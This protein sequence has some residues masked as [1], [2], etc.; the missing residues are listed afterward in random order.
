MSRGSLLDRSMRRRRTTGAVAAMVGLP[1]ELAHYT[2][3]VQRW[4]AGN[5]IQLLRAG[6]ETYPA[7]YAAIAS[8]NVSICVETYILDDDGV[9][10]RFAD[11][12][13]E[14]ARAGIT[15]RVLYD[16]VGGW[17]IDGGYLDRLR[18]DGVRVAEFHPIAPWRRRWGLSRRDHRKILVVDDRV[19]FT[20]GLNLSDDYAPAEEGGGDWHDIHCELHGPIVADL[21]RLFRKTWIYSGG[22]NYPVAAEG[23]LVPAVDGAMTF[24]RVLDNSFR[25]R[26]RVIRR[27][28]LVAINAARH[29]VLLANAYFLPDRGLRAALRRAVARGVVVRVIVPGRSDVLIVELAALYLYRRLVKAG[30]EILRWR[31][32]MMHAKT[33]VIDGVWATIGSYNLDSISLQRNLEVTVETLDR[34]HGAIMRAQHATDATH[35][36]PFTEEAWHALPWWRRAISWLAYQ[37]ERWL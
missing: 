24:A 29:E 3:D 23:S 37:F 5:R 6:R 16:A 35:C 19:A 25:R 32:T 7:M 26:R 33:A 15:V 30:V 28:Y 31:G 8:A 14:R 27:A 11:A 17:G 12:L 20:G 36:A 2:R 9:G 18:R 10:R 21:S 4:R 1:R 13:C 34:E 22:D